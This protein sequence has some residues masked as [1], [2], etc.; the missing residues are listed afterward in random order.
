MIGVSTGDENEL[1]YLDLNARVLD[2]YQAVRF[3]QLGE[4]GE[5]RS[6]FGS[7]SL[8]TKRQGTR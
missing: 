2:K 8:F 3:P 6:V 7:P 5:K 1:A 4:G